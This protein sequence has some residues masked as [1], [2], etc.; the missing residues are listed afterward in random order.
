MFEQNLQVAAQ[1]DGDF[2][3]QVLKL[4]LKQMNTFLIRYIS[5][6]MIFNRLFCFFRFGW[7]SIHTTVMLKSSFIHSFIQA[8]PLC[9]LN[10]TLC[11]LYVAIKPSQPAIYSLLGW[12]LSLICICVFRYR[13]EV[14]VYKE[15]HLRDRQLPQFY[16]Q[17]M[18]AIINNCQTFKWVNYI[19]RWQIIY[20]VWNQTVEKVCSVS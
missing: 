6:S 19:N 11:V 13:E 7:V 18:I 9:I 10:Y 5:D 20:C 14:V 3:E 8:K 4:C 17:Y 15:E 1:I 12:W 16:V 2:K